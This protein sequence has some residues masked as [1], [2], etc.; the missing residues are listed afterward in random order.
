MKQIA[1]LAGL[2]L[3]LILLAVDGAGAADCYATNCTIGSPQ[4][5][6]ES[7]NATKQAKDCYATN[8]TLGSPQNVTESKSGADPKLDDAMKQ[9]SKD[10][11]RSLAAPKTLEPTTEPTRP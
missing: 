9:L 6:T 11:Q 4:N 5:V 7:N 8:C 1:I 10:T 2:M 3:A